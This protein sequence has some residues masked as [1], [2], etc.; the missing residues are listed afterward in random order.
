MSPYSHLACSVEIWLVLILSSIPP[1]RP[2]FVRVYRKTST[3]VS[4]KNRTLG[5]SNGRSHPRVEDDDMQL[6]LYSRSGY[7]AGVAQGTRAQ[8]HTGG[9]S[10][11]EID[12][13]DDNDSQE[14]ILPGRI[15]VTTDTS[16]RRDPASRSNSKVVDPSDGG[17]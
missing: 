10:V 17:R 6:N 11:R 15:W 16:I 3:V 1:L 4:S 14:S 12:M 2:L 8:H 5:A 13:F 7:K 9:A